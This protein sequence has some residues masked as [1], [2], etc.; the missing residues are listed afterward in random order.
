MRCV[1][2]PTPAGTSL[3]EGEHHARSAH[4]VP[5]ERNTSFG[6]IP[7]GMLPGAIPFVSYGTGKHQGSP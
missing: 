2:P 7:Y 4:I 5:R 1:P 6:N 3:V